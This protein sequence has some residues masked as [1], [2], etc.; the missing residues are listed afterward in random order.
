MEKSIVIKDGTSKAQLI[1]AIRNFE[2]ALG[3]TVL[4]MHVHDNHYYTLIEFDGISVSKWIGII[5]EFIEGVDNSKM[6]LEEI[7]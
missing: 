4:I 5:D 6:I 2:T 1:K 7:L 3:T